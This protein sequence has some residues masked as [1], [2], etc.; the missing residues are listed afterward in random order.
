MKTYQATFEVEFKVKDEQE[1][2]K[3]VKQFLGDDLGVQGLKVTDVCLSLKNGS[4]AI[5]QA[6][7][8]ETYANKQ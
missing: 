5:R 1:A 4:Y 6:Q 7:G 3:L 8:G 2:L